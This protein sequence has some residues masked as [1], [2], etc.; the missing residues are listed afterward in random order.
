MKRLAFLFYE[1]VP[2][3]EVSLVIL[4]KLTFLVGVSIVS[5]FTR[6]P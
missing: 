6:L 2:V 3:P 5:N 4:D 1:I